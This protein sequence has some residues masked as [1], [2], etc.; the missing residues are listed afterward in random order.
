MNRK[1]DLGLLIRRFVIVLL[2]IAARY[3]RVSEFLLSL[4]AF[5]QMLDNSVGGGTVEDVGALIKESEDN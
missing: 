4:E 5:K 1:I 3:F 2:R